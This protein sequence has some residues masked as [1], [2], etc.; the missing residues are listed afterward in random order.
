MS[1]IFPPAKAEVVISGRS[2]RGEERVAR[3]RARVSV[4]GVWA[5]DCK[6]SDLALVLYRRVAV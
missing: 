6:G 3:A 5:I 4:V 1:L 2:E